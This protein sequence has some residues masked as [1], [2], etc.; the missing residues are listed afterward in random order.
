MKK[1]IIITSFLSSRIKENNFS[2]GKNDLIICA[3]GGYD[4][5]L[6][7]DI[8][9]DLVIG[10]FDSSNY[11]TAISENTEIIRANPEKDDTDTFLCL[12]YG[13][14][15]GFEDFLIIG[16]LGGRL[17]HTFANLQTM[18]YAINHKKSIGILD[19]NNMAFMIGVGKIEIERMEGYKISL[20]SFTNQCKVTIE[21]VKYPL[22]NYLMKNNFPIGT[23]NEF[24]SP[25]ASIT[26]L[27]GKLLIIL[28]KES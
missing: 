25:R 4:F 12:K 13:I 8:L 10:D 16:G 20:F 21:G 5:A 11:N 9:P 27:E 1:C 26:N 3:D 22:N 19:G 24:L 17:D 7:E 18:S 6:S 23:S 14:G 2:I 28:T 15:K